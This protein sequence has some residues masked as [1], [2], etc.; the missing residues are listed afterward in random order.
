MKKMG[1]RSILCAL[2]LLASSGRVVRAQVLYGSL[3][4][5]VNDPTGAPIPGAHVEAVNQETNVK[6]ETD[7]DAHGVYHFTEVQSGVY[8]VTV[9]AKSFRTFIETSVQVQVATVR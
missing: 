4:G 5:N 3:T 6:N 2:V 8:K 1:L 7:T 9:S